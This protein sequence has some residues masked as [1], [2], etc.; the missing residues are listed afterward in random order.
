MPVSDS[1]LPRAPLPEVSTWLSV[2]PGT[3]EITIQQM[4]GW[5]VIQSPWK[6]YKEEAPP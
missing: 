1:L 5:G 3:L 4:M 6:N 2:P